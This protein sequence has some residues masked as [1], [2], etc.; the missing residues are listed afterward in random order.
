MLLLVLVLTGAALWLR[1]VTFMAVL[2]PS[3]A[4]VVSAVVMAGVVLL[5]IAVLELPVAFYQGY[6]LEH[7]Y[8]LSTQ[9]LPHWLADQVKGV[10]VSLTIGTGGAAVVY[11][12]LAVSNSWWWLIAAVAFAAGTVVLARLAPVL[13]L[14]LFFS[15][16]P[17][18]RPQLVSRLLALAERA[19]TDV[20]GVFE[21]RVSTHTHK[22]N[23]AL[24]GM[25]RTR[26]ILLSDTLLAHCTDDEIEVVLAH[27]LSHHVHHDL[28]RAVGLQSGLLFSG[29]FLA[30][31]ALR[32][33]AASIG[34]AGMSDPA[35]LPLLM[36]V[37]GL[38]SFL[39][40]PLGNALS[41]S[42]ERRADRYALEMTGRAD[43]FVSA[44]RRLAHQNMAEEHPSRL[45]Q[46]L[47]YS[48]PP[49][50]ERIRFAQHWASDRCA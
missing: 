16:K 14:P 40:V 39:L 11:T 1:E 48:H 50:R 49:I 21:W 42:H 19:R 34:L 7:R 26:R 46:W 2:P 15:F 13:L 38:W 47:F 28:W 12:A 20:M 24:A 10:V 4:D 43:A 27:E 5:L 32:H 18:D 41:R 31:L 9:L 25:G 33:L 29:F 36:L 3:I 30:D 22:A 44:M 6:Y 37:G 17:L 8:G 23:A 35:G 45:V